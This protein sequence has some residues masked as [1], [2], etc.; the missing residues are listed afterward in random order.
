M[1]LILTEQLDSLEDLFVKHLKQLYDAEQRIVD[2]LPEMARIASAVPLKRLFV[3][4]LDQSREHIHRLEEIFGSLD[5]RPERETCIA[6]KS[7]LIEADDTMDAKGDADVRDA[8][9]IAAAQRVEHYE[10][11]SYG[12]ARTFA[13]RLGHFDAARLL[14]NT[15]R[16]EART[17]DKLTDVAENHVNVRAVH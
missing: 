6:V 13:L 1:G 7:L 3:E 16:E 11:A 9:L 12:T 4:D 2:A 15:L 5:R 17:N 8:A 14:Q 10:I